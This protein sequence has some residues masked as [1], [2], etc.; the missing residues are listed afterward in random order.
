[1]P[2]NGRLVVEGVSAPGTLVE[3]GS[4]FGLDG[5]NLM[6]HPDVGIDTVLVLKLSAALEMRTRKT[7]AV[8]GLQGFA[9]AFML[10]QFLAG[11]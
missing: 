3:G 5:L 2:R 11:S 4:V 1:M 9:I 7:G 8:L 10:P 6:L